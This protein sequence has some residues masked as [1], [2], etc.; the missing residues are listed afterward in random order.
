MHNLEELSIHD[1][2]LSLAHLPRVFRTCI[3]V[4]KLSL[5]LYES[6]LDA[7]QEDVDCFYRGFGRL[8]HLKIIRAVPQRVPTYLIDAWPV[9]LEV[10]R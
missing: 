8:T 9:I 4:K 7:Y 3:K 1:T 2:K 6:N 10:L 5:N